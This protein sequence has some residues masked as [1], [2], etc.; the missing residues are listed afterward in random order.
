MAVSGSNE[1]SLYQM[2]LGLV[3]LVAALVLSIGYKLGLTKSL[4]VGAIR[5]TVQLVIVSYILLWVFSLNDPWVI[6]ALLIVMVGAA[7]Q[8]AGNRIKG[9]DT[10]KKRWIYQKILFVSIFISSIVTLAYLQ[11]VV[12]R[13][14]P[15]WEGR[16]IVPLGGMIIGQSMN[17]GSL[18]V[19]RF[20]S[21]LD[22]R[23]GEIETLLALGA[24]TNQAALSSVRMSCGA[25]LMPIVNMLMV[26][27]IVS[28]PGLMS[29][30]ILSGVS[31]LLAVRYQLLICFAMVA[32]NALVAWLCLAQAKKIYFTSVDQ[33]IPV[34]D[35]KA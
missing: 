1:I 20:R 27:G 34:A 12:L 33:F 6:S 8:A 21:E 9:L 25:A 22:I 15:L 3:P 24:T 19:E 17:A 23:T 18:V 31:P 11:F 2:G 26:L 14:Q 30:Q 35:A 7:T 28:L 32:S 13:T 10:R 4:I 29:G 5:G 16:Y